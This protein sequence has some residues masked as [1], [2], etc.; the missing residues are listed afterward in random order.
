MAEKDILFRQKIR[1]TGVFDFKEL[2]R[3]LFEWLVDQGYDVNEKQYKEIIGAGNAREIEVEWKATRKVSDYFKFML[4]MK[5]HL[6]GITNVEVEIDG[7]KQKMQKGQFEIEV[8][9]TLLKDY[10]ERWTKTPFVKFLRGLYD[11]YIIK[12]R[13]EAYEAKIVSEM[14]MFIAECKSFLALSGAR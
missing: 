1:H 10:E 14:D 13:I 2:Y 9:S 4:E 6:L 3:I 12:E 5:W 11:K 7:K 8:R